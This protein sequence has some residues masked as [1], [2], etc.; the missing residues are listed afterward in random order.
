MT[1]AIGLLGGTFDP[2]HRAH[3]ALALAARDALALD[4]VRLLPAAAPWQRGPLST[5]G[6]Q[7]L[8][9]LQLAV[10]D[11]PGLLVDATEITRGGKTYTIDTV[12]QLPDNAPGKARYVWIL[13]S[14]QLQNFC[15]W[16]RWQDIIQY[17][18]LAVAQRPDSP[19]ESPPELTQ[20]LE[21]LGRSISRIPF[22]PM[23]VSASEIRQH[24]AVGMPVDAF[25][26]PAVAA[27]I[28]RHGLYQ[29]AAL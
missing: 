11:H 20:R 15:T 1:Q 9:M 10:A 2:V 26:A 4:Q 24:I 23:T 6:Q 29:P 27:Y 21:T 17:V 8:D 14:D 3:I 16:H 5:T 19:L 12:S 25:L 28:Q 22:T 7:R 13:G 18:D